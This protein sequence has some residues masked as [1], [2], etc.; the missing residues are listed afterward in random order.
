MHT[1]TLCSFATT[2]PNE[3]L[4]DDRA[5]M[6]VHHMRQ[7]IISAYC[8]VL[9]ENAHRTHINSHTQD[10]RR[11]AYDIW[12]LLHTRQLRPQCEFGMRAGGEAFLRRLS[13]RGWWCGDRA[14]RSDNIRATCVT[15]GV[16]TTNVLCESSRR[17]ARLCDRAVRATSN[18]QPR[19]IDFQFEY[20]Q[21]L[22]CR[23]A[24]NVPIV[25]VD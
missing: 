8:A 15:E 4:R 21:N 12:A 2:P 24:G 13:T 6:L 25:V 20:T 22:A 5:S 19:R 9:V 17:G 10:A 11:I 1:Y 23:C 16:A 18:Q 3:P 14:P 7:K